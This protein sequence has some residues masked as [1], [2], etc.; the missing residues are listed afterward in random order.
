MGFNDYPGN[1]QGDGFKYLDG[2]NLLFEGALILA[3]SP[4]QVSDAARGAQQGSSQN[5]DFTTV[6]PFVLNSPGTIADVEGTCIINDDNAG[7]NK[8]GL[9]IKLNSFSFNDLEN[10]NYILLKYDLTNK[11]TSVI[12]NLYAGLFF[13]WDFAD[14]ANDFTAYDTLGNF[15]YAYRVG[16]NPDTW[17]ASALVSSDSFGFWA[18]NNQGGDGGFSIY[19][20]FSDTE[21]WQ[22]L[23]SGI[24]KPQAGAW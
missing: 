22:S 24:G 8:L 5:N 4:T 9:I 6:Q 15:G 19:D 16:G 18:I 11:T 10:Q 2:S 3:T 17:V 23:S 14:A 12:N 1:L 13:D 21:K 7:T 20:G